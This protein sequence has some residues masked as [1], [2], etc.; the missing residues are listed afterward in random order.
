LTLCQVRTAA[1]ALLAAWLL[2]GAADRRRR[3]ERAAEAIRKT[4]ASN[5]AARKSHTKARRRRLRALGI[6]VER[7]TSCIPP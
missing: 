1:E 5:A 4:Q 3:I 6:R 7:L 2:A